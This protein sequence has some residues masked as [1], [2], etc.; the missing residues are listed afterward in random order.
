M[1]AGKMALNMINTPDGSERKR[2]EIPRGPIAQPISGS[3]RS[4]MTRVL[5][6]WYRTI[7]S[8]R[9]PIKPRTFVIW[10]PV[11]DAGISILL[12][13][14]CIAFGEQTI[15]LILYPFLYNRQLANLLN[16]SLA[17]PLCSNQRYKDAGSQRAGFR[18][19]GCPV[20]DQ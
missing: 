6:T 15:F 17:P 4:T 20:N 2:A 11:I 1:S 5:A 18:P 19:P 16:R 13:P 9:K 3:L 8:I 14:V 7:H 12:A 10:T